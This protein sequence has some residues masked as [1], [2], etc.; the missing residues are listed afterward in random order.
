MTANA[1]QVAHGGGVNRRD[2]FVAVIDQLVS[3]LTYATH[4]GGSGDE[5][6]Q[7][8]V[9]D[10][11]GVVTMLTSTN[12]GNF[13]TTLNALDRTANGGGATWYGSDTAIAQI[14]PSRAPAQQLV[15]GTYLGGSGA[16]LPGTVTLSAAGE[17]V[18]CGTTTSPNFPTTANAF[19]ST[20]RGGA[21]DVNFFI[22]GDGF[23]A[24]I[25]PALSGAAGLIAATY[26]GGGGMD[27]G[28]ACSCDLAGEMTLVGWSNANSTVPTTPDAMRRVY[29]G[30]DGYLARFSS[31]A[32]QL[33][34]GS[35]LGGTNYDGAWR[36][37]AHADGTSTIVGITFSN[38]LP[39]QNAVQPARSGGDDI[40]IQRVQTIPTGTLRRGAPSLGS[41]GQPTIHAMGDAV[42]NNAQFGIACSRAPISK[43]G[44]ILFGQQPVAGVPLFGINLYVD[45]ASL[46]ATPFV[47]SDIRGEVVWP[48]PLPSFAFGT[49][50]AQ[51][52]WLEVASTITLSASDAL[53]IH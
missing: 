6:L 7:K 19:Q 52:V 39:V 51:F 30:E 1:F 10:G 17:I 33:L 53:Q 32:S 50:H 29:A 49:L 42:A 24:K 26:C 23:L 34:Y 15:Y 47:Q 37:H 8:V 31:D 13:P 2:G 40:L 16:D 3:T 38:D 35:L 41:N 46:I 48:L 9:V 22:A 43:L 5:F 12:S 21:Y 45:Q 11:N 25:N 36:V 18:V 44:A 4:V 28:L 14:D 27:Q 20:F